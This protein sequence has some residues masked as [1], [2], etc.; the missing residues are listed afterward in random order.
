MLKLDIGCGKNKTKSQDEHPF[1]GI[2]IMKFEGV[3]L[4]CDLSKHTWM[5]KSPI[6]DVIPEYGEGVLTDWQLK[7]DSVD[8]VLSSHFVEHL[9]GD[10]R[11]LF[12]NE[13]YRIMKP[14]STALI[15]TPDWSHACAYGDPTHKWPPMSS[16]YALYLNKEWRDVNAP[17]VPFNCNFGW[18][19]GASWDEWLNTR[20]N[21]MKTFAM[22][23]YINSVRDLHVTLIKQ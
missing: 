2:D 17:H 11:I 12:F 4:V 10:E 13:L 8:E 5:F 21:E 9:T 19:H 6:N 3:D 20:N 1:T 23:R 7:C 15:I 14:G 22:Q 18:T 16:W